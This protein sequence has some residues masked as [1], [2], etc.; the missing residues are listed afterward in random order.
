MTAKPTVKK[1]ATAK[2]KVTPSNNETVPV[3][4]AAPDEAGIAVNTN[5]KEK[6]SPKVYKPEDL[7]LC[8]SVISG[9]LLFSINK[10]NTSY[11]WFN[12][13]DTAWVEYQDLL[14]AMVSRSDYIYEPLFV[15][16]D[17]ELLE[18]PKWSEVKKLYNSMQSMYDIDSIVSLPARKFRPVFESLPLSIKN[19]VKS[20]VAG[21]IQAGEFDSIGVVKIIDE[22]C[23]T[24]LKLLLD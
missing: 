14:S 21:L 4:E 3:T 13:G 7:I 10:T 23:G 16:E 22:M 1:T 9:I 8:R 18:D 2:P 5:T 15:I 12:D 17:E 19:T 11:K 6:N 24:D 20:K